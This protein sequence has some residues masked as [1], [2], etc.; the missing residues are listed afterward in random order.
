MKL[1]F[2]C[3][4]EQEAVAPCPQHVFHD[5][6]M[7]EKSEDRAVVESVEIQ[8][9]RGVEEHQ[10]EYWKF[11]ALRKN[12]SSMVCGEDAFWDLMYVLTADDAWRESQEYQHALLAMD[13]PTFVVMEDGR[14]QSILVSSR[15]SYGL[16]VV[17][18]PVHFQSVDFLPEIGAFLYF[19]VDE[20]DC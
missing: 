6:W 12:H 18:A 1:E 4:I 9:G 15:N 19:V 16:M 7:S 14:D 5:S 13:C 11:S 17:I 10:V 20:Y 2:A 3:Q 8:R